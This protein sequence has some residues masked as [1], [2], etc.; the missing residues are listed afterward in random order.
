MGEPD[1]WQGAYDHSILSGFR[2]PFE[3]M[4]CFGWQPLVAVGGWGA[5][6]TLP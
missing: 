1:G 3:W 4:R 6:P 5:T 2:S